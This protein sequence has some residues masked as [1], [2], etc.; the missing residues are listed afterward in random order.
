MKSD[1]TEYLQYINNWPCSNTKG[2]LLVFIQCFKNSAFT[3]TC[4]LFCVSFTSFLFCPYFYVFFSGDSSNFNLP[5][6]NRSNLFM[7]PQCLKYST[8]V[9]MH[10]CFFIHSTFIFLIFLCFL[11]RRQLLYDCSRTYTPPQSMHRRKMRPTP[12]LHPRGADR[13]GS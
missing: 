11:F 6:S 8:F 3:R 9:P 5:C 7:S 4:K 2:N 10:M 1:S 12:W 13:V